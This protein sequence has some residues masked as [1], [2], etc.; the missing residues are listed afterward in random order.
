MGESSW[1]PGGKLVGELH[2]SWI[3]PWVRPWPFYLTTLGRSHRIDFT[4]ALHPQLGFLSH[5]TLTLTGSITIAL[6]V[7]STLALLCHLPSLCPIAFSL[8]HLL[9]KEFTLGQI[10]SSLYH[11]LQPGAPMADS[12]SCRHYPVSGLRA[13]YWSDPHG[14]AKH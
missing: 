6:W 7:L 3:P 13:V 14:A 1:T 11:N 5:Y 8:P 12:Q 4:D 2:D 10:P 9:E